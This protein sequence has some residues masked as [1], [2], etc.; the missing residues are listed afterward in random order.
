MFV[1]EPKSKFR[2]W[3]ITVRAGAGLGLAYK[4]T[5]T[6][7][8]GGLHII[9]AHPITKENTILVILFIWKYEC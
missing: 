3:L 2:V 1:Y 6:V 7:H 5:I 9:N 8:R 4:S